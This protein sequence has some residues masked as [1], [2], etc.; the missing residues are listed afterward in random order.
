MS[1]P[2]KYSGLIGFATPPWETHLLI[3]LFHNDSLNL[4]SLWCDDLESS[5][6]N[7]HSNQLHKVVNPKMTA[8]TFIWKTDEL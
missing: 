4:L 7:M 1:Q 8:G 6:K 2:G 3:L 5:S